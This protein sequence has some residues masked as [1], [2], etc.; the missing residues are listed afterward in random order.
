MLLD[1]F[2]PFFLAARFFRF[3]PFPS[4]PSILSFQI[5][6]QMTGKPRSRLAQGHH[7]WPAKRALRA[8]L[9]VRDGMVKA[10]TIRRAGHRI[11]PLRCNASPK[12]KRFLRKYIR[13]NTTVRVC[14]DGIAALKDALPLDGYRGAG[15]FKC[16]RCLF[17]FQQFGKLNAHIPTC[18]VVR[19]PIPLRERERSTRQISLWVRENTTDDNAFREVF[20]KRLY[21]KRT[22]LFRLEDAATWLDL[23]GH[24]G[25]FS[26]LALARGCEVITFEPSSEEADLLEHNVRS[27]PMSA[28]CLRTCLLLACL[29][30]FL[31]ACLPACLRACLTACLP[32]CLPACMPACLP[33][34]LLVC[35]PACLCACPP[36][37]VRACVPACLPACLPARLPDVFW[38]Q[39]QARSLGG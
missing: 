29:R 34:C 8:Q 2:R 35:L 1:V 17:G 30:A 39:N 5:C 3:P 9:S 25:T 11:V 4:L 37:C 33:A 24:I 20:E 18:D 14:P 23:G 22:K 19:D 6:L 15:F 12:K 10:A 16:G 28:C 13:K 7:I 31:P 21:E 32:A 38:F 26:C 36:A 27:L